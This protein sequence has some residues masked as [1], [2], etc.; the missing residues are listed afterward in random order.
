M[1][2][3]IHIGQNFNLEPRVPRVLGQRV[4]ALATTREATA[5]Q[6]A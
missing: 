4:V 6:D 2:V 5:G 3:D 1:D